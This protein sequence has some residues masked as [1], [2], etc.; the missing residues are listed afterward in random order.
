MATGVRVAV[1][2]L[3][4]STAFLIGYV[5]L[6][7]LRAALVMAGIVVVALSAIIFRLSGAPAATR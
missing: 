3:V 7:P 1:F 2:T 6:V 5:L 4:V